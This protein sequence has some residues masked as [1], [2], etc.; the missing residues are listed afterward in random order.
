MSSKSAVAASSS[1]K[2]AASAGKAKAGKVQSYY[3]K[4]PVYSRSGLQR[5]RGSWAIKNKKKIEKKKVAPKKVEK[6]FGGK[7]LALVRPRASRTYPAAVR[8][9]THKES[10]PVAVRE[11]ITKGTILILLAGRF[12]GRRVVA[13]RTLPSGLVV[14]TGP[15]KLN[16]V[17]LRRVNPAYVIA[18]STKIDL[19]GIKIDAKINDSYFRKPATKETEK[20]SAQHFF[21]GQRATEKTTPAEKIADQKAVDAAIVAAVKKVPMMAQYLG[22]SFS[23]NKNQVPHTLKF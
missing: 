20:K 2:P 4:L 16:G 5:A 19:K 11:S 21:A 23:I 22:T 10:R 6:T 15:F 18:T 14:V 8:R 1:Q 17:P 9:I 12:R 13:L 3:G 7:P